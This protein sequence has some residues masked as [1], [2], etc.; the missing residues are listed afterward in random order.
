[1]NAP[2]P[3]QGVTI[4][5]GKL[6]VFRPGLRPITRCGIRARRG[7][8]VVDDV[9]ADTVPPDQRCRNCF[10]GTSDRSTGALP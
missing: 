6:H 7:Q 2:T 8:Q 3:V 1:V 9:P 10:P 5:G 4:N